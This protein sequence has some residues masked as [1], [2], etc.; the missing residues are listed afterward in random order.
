MEKITDLTQIVTYLGV[1]AFFVSCITEV[2]KTW[3]WLNDKIPTG[4]SVVLIALL[5]CPISMIA[6]CI[7]FGIVI[8][9]YMVYASFIAAFIVALIAMDGWERVTD[10]ASKMIKKS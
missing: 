2:L 1:M 6:I 8:E 3:K 9:W 5:V 4:L 10:I 7:Y